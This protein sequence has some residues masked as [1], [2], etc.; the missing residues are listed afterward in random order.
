MT[1]V[2]GAKECDGCMM[3]QEPKVVLKSDDGEPI[4]EGDEYFDIN[5]LILT[6]DELEQYRKVA[7]E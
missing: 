6:P 3:C 1:C 5:G 2:T 4:Y 7:G